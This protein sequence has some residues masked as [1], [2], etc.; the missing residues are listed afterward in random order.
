MDRKLKAILMGTGLLVGIYVTLQIARIVWFLAILMLPILGF[1]A[2]VYFIGYG[3]PSLGYYGRK[4]HK[5][6]ETK[7]RSAL[8]W[9]D[10]TAPAWTWPAIRGARTFLDWLGLQVGPA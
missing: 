4:L 9:L 10:F 8:D 6:A 3:A 7:A 1:A 5:R 2:F